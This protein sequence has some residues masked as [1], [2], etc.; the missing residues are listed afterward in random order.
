MVNIPNIHPYHL[1][2]PRNTN[3]YTDK[4]EGFRDAGLYMDGILDPTIFNPQL[5]ISEHIQY[6]RKWCP[7]FAKYKEASD[8]ELKS[9]FAWCHVQIDRLTDIVLNVKEHYLK[10]VNETLK[11]NIGRGNRPQKE[12]FDQGAKETNKLNT[13]IETLAF[14]LLTRIAFY[15]KSTNKTGCMPFI[16]M[17]K[18][19]LEDNN[20]NNLNILYQNVVVDDLILKSDAM[21]GGIHS[22]TQ[23]KKLTKDAMAD[24]ADVAIVPVASAASAASAASSKSIDHM[25]IYE[26]Y[27]NVPIRESKDMQKFSELPKA[28]REYYKGGANKDGYIDISNYCYC[29]SV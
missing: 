29:R 17:I 22:M 16:R 26:T 27:K 24:V 4:I 20:N 2:D 10:F 6:M 7:L 14:T 5:I 23:I 8:E 28:F 12:T 15:K 21:T 19:L 1:T 13:M 9:H 3:K 18:K 11:G 25:E